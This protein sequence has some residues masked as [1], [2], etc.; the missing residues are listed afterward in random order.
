[1]ADYSVCFAMLPSSYSNSENIGGGSAAVAEKV[2]EKMH[3]S[4]LLPQMTG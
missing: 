1:M 3:P 4:N 2:G